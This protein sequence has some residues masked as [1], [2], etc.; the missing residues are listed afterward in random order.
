MPQ[1]QKY[2]VTLSDG[3][4]FVVE[5]DGPPSEQDVMAAL[6]TQAEPQKAPAQE[7][8]KTD[9]FL[10]DNPALPWMARAG[11]WGLRQI[12]KHPV[13]SA[14][15]AG[16]IAAAP[17]TAGASIPAAMTA[18]GLGAAGGAGLA[19]TGRQLL[20]GRPESGVDTAKTMA[21]QGLLNAA[22]EG[23]GQGVVKAG[24]VVIPKVLKGI[25]RPS[26][27]IQQR[28]G[29]VVGTMRGERIPVG[30]SAVADA[31]VTESADAVKALLRAKDAERPVVR[32]YLNPAR[33]EIPLGNPQTT[34][35]KGTGAMQ[36]G[37]L[38]EPG[39][40]APAGMVDPREIPTGLADARGDLG[41][42]ALA[43]EGTGQLDEMVQ[44]FLRQ[45]NRP[46]SLM[47]TNALKQAEQ[48]LADTAYKAESMGHPVNGIEGMFHEGMA[49]G[50]QRAVESRVP[51]V[52]G[53]NTRTRDLMGLTDALQD[54]EARSGA[55]IMNLNPLS[56]VG[57]VA[58]G[59]GSKAAFAADSAA[60]GTQGT[61]ARLIRQAL[62]SL[63]A[64]DSPEGPE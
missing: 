46:M 16:A 4:K 55:G 38:H 54:A 24:E 18:A 2:E 34:M 5:A 17:F 31:R 21:T 62:L 37:V 51:E 1:A 35:P 58:P 10:A 8:S 57:N 14:A 60:K 25:L 26:K 49:G 30:Q 33:E 9:T 43:E 47:E 29:D 48:K 27:A 36:G 12:K 15:T 22:G 13:E 61:Q 20:T 39:P 3:R 6:G 23:F 11:Q 64:G 42:R 52:A 32:G 28:F 50:A 44:S 40:G 59:L 19:I 45:R 41:N 53:M 63:L 56:W 7:Q